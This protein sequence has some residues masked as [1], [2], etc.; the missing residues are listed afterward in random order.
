MRDGIGV[1]TRSHWNTMTVGTLSWFFDSWDAF[2]L[3]YVLSD[4]A[5]TFGMTVSAMS[6][7]LLFTYLS[8][9]LGGLLFGSL[10]RSWGRKRSLMLAIAVFGGF[11]MLTGLAPS[12][13]ALLL[14]RLCFGLGM[15]GVYASAGPLVV[16]SVPNAVRGFASGFFMLGFYLGNAVAPWTYY[17][18]APSLGWR[19]LFLF[20]GVSLLLVPYIWLTVPESPVWQARNRELAVTA[21]RGVRPLPFW[22]V[23]APGFIGTTLALMLIE[24]GEFLHSFPFQSLLPTFLKTVRHAPISQVALAGSVMGVGAMLG[25]LFGGWISDKIGRKRTFILGYV[26]GVIP[27]AVALLSA[28]MTVIVVASFVDGF[29]FG[30]LAGMVT[31]YENEHFPTDLRAVGNGFIHNLGALSGSVGAVIA[32]L[33]HAAVGWSL[34]I[35]LVGVLG[36]V[37]GLLGLLF[38]RETVNSSLVE[39]GHGNADPAA[40]EVTDDK[41]SP[42]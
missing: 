5:K 41:L 6:L 16:E 2:L 37:L 24:F 3:I 39:A 4:M 10:A 7:A 1:L 35:I 27:I 25:S 32:A 28:D 8:R 42:A 30:S 21:T 18:L 36:T 33:L 9:W 13:Q 29:I 15:G 38:T 11:T 14:I 31:A 34:T 17:V 23:F 40:H 19:G 20:G 22:K 26:L 12:F